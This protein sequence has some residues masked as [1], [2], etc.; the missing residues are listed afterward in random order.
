MAAAMLEGGSASDEVSDIWQNLYETLGI[1]G[2]SLEEVAALSGKGADQIANLTDED[3]ILAAALK[4]VGSSLGTYVEGMDGVTT[5]Q[6]SYIL[7]TENDIEAQQRLELSIREAMQ[8]I[9]DAE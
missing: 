8:A 1:G 6:E 9:T 7:Q 3:F 2:T 4:L 5:A